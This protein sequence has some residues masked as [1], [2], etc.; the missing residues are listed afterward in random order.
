MKL[1]SI[2]L[3]NYN[4]ARFMARLLRAI[5]TD[6][7]PSQIIVIDYCS[8]DKSLEV[9]EEFASM[10]VLGSSRFTLRLLGHTPVRQRK[11]PL[12]SPFT[13]P[14]LNSKELYACI[15]SFEPTA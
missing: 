6:P 14:N 10:T 11:I 3:P 15:W 4:H 5:D 1:L 9:I 2:L 12:A 7:I 8:T 13:S